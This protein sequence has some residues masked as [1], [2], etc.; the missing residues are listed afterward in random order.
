MDIKDVEKIAIHTQARPEKSVVSFFPRIKPV[1]KV[2]GLLRDSTNLDRYKLSGR[3][4]KI[5]NRIQPFSY[6][7]NLDLTWHIQHEG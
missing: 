3:R 5:W 4:K 6:H 1:A 2:G 7:A